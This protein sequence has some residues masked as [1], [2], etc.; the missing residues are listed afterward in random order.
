MSLLIIVVILAIIIRWLESERYFW[1]LAWPGTVV[2]E[3]LHYA[4]ALVTFGQPSSFNV[5]P[6][7]AKNGQIVMGSVICENLNWLNR[8]PI[9]LAPLLALPLGFYAATTYD[10]T[11][12]WQG[13]ASAWVLASVIGGAW[14]SSQDFRVGFSSPVGLVAWGGV[15]YMIV[16]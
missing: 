14:P 5:W 2:H 10:F 9:A 7:P 11:W 3:A 1:I 8:L 6:E 16:R 15:L 12:S 4:M 13:I